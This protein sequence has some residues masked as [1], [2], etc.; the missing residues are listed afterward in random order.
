MANFI[1]ISLKSKQNRVSSNKFS[2]DTE[3][4]HAY[5]HKEFVEIDRAHNEAHDR[6]FGPWRVKPGGLSVIFD[7][8]KKRFQGLLEISSQNC[9]V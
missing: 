3:V 8:S 7:F 2:Q 5:S 9:P 1:G 4:S 6:I